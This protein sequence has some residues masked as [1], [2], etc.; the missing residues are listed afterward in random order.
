[1]IKHNTKEKQSLCQVIKTDE[2]IEIENKWTDRESWRLQ[3]SG[4]D[5]KGVG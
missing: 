4:P 2:S 1:M 5:S 3:I